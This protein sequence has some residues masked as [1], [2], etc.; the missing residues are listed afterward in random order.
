MYSLA[1]CLGFLL[2]MDG[3]LP[4]MAFSR[5]LDIYDFPKR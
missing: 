5:K 4:F 2:H 3:I 1:V